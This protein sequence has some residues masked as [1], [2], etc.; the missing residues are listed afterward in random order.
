LASE[1]LA[2]RDLRLKRLQLLRRHVT[3]LDLR[4]KR[5]IERGKET[6]VSETEGKRR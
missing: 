4:I 6:D 5:R 1:C 3:K 2:R